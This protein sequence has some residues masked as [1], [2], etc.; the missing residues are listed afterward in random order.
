ML[1]GVDIRSYNVK[2]L[3]QQVC[4]GLLVLHLQSKQGW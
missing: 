2:W 4:P 1:D 3:R